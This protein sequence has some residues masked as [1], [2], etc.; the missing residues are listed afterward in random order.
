VPNNSDPQNGPIYLVGMMGAGKSTIG[1]GLAARLGYA[2]LDTD[3]EVERTTG[4]TIVE[5]FERDGEA[6]FRVLEAEVIDR[7][8]ESGAMVVALG[9]GAIAQAGAVDRLLARGPVVFL[10]VAPEILIERIGEG[11]SRPL[12]A[13]L[14]R[15]GQVERLAAL[16]AERLIHYERA[17]LTVDASQKADEVVEAIVAGLAR[18]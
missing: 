11:S 10:R 16:L 12:L 7:A 9:G 15:A 17:S 6:R 5:I 4:R 3:S 1:P 18:G 14:D 2:F 13:G 8:S